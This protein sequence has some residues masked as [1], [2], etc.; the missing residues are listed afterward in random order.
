LFRKAVKVLRGGRNKRVESE[1]TPQPAPFC[2]LESLESRL[3]MSTV[4]IASISNAT[5]GG[6]NG[7]F[8]IT[9]DDTVGDLVVKFSA[10]GGSGL[11]P[12][13]EFTLNDGV[14]N[15][16]KSVVIP[17]GAAFVNINLVANDDLL[18]EPTENI[19]IKLL[20]GSG[21]VLTPDFSIRSAT[22]SI[23]DNEPRVTVT[24][25]DTTAAE[26]GTPATNTGS[27][28]VTRTG[29]TVGD[30]VVSFKLTGTAKIGKDF[31]LLVGA[32]PITK[33][34][35]IPDGQASVVIT[36]NPIEDARYEPTENVNIALRATRFYTVGNGG[37][38]SVI[39]EDNEPLIFVDPSASVPLSFTITTANGGADAYVQDG[40]EA[41]D[42]HDNVPLEI[43]NADGVLFTDSRKAYLRFNM[44]LFP[45]NNFSNAILTL[46]LVARE[47]NSP[48]NTNFT[49]NVFGLKDDF[50]P[51]TGEQAENWNEAI[52]YGDAPGNIAGG[53]TVDLTDMFGGGP[54]GSFNVVGNGTIGQ[55]VSISG[56]LLTDYLNNESIIDADGDNFV[57]FVIVRENVGAPNDT[58]IHKFGSRD[59]GFGD[60]PEL[61]GIGEVVGL[62]VDEGDDTTVRIFRAGSQTGDIT[63][64]FSVRGSARL[65]IDYTLEVNGSP[66][67]SSFVIPDGEDFVDITVITI[68]DGHFEIPESIELILRPRPGYVLDN[69]NVVA[70]LH[71][72][73]NEP[74]V[75]VVATDDEAQEPDTGSPTLDQGVFTLART[76]SVFGS[77]S[78]TVRFK[79]VAINGKDFQTIE[80]Q[81]VFLP[82]EA[83]VDVTINPL[84]D[85][86]PEGAEDLI[87]EIV[88]GTGYGLSWILTGTRSS[89]GSDLGPRIIGAANLRDARQLARNLGFSG[90]TIEPDDQ[91]DLITILNGDLPP[92]PDLLIAKFQITLNDVRNVTQGGSFG[93]ITIKNAGTQ[94]VGAFNVH[95]FLSDDRIVGDLD[96]FDLGTLTIQ[97]LGAGK[98]VTLAI[99]FTDIAGANP[100]TY[101]LFADVDSGGFVTET[102]ENNNLTSTAG[103]AIRIRP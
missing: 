50:V 10:T 26:S 13:R 47:G 37:V 101:L 65:G 30:L 103:R 28:T 99:I 6:A 60:P 39:I 43:R 67:T 73:D 9:R 23:I 66:I 76:G 70:R 25:T 102:I 58:I 42:P 46:T 36:I 11:G 16:T 31:T 94:S 74:V 40:S 90:P 8:R 71:I 29:S 33:T 64:P 85:A 35:T 98:S 12:T 38:A 2:S 62:E 32:D 15:L 59:D 1:P 97:S 44:D 96:D 63:V 93:T 69:N 4:S 92:G 53:G 57:T 68:D 91:S 83:T 55:R 34:V 84:G 56:Q 54:L 95:L 22:G 79:G 89:T 82:F 86:I 3:L 78:V 72:N 51:A 14:N 48:G 18:A 27:F 45:F 17:D 87:L 7:L 24:A 49:Y 41:T 75:T 100:G 21:Y 19:T 52:V 77:L 88:P 80:K 5:E 20:A 61:T 81:V